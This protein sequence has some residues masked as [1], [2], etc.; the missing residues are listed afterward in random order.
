MRDVRAHPE[1]YVKVSD[2]IREVIDKR[3]AAG[4]PVWDFIDPRRG[5]AA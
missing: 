5:E 2:I 1:N 4:K 3:R